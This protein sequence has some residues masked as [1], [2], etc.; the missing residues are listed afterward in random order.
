MLL[1]HAG[2]RVHRRINIDRSID[3]SVVGPATHRPSCWPARTEAV[4]ETDAKM[5][6]APL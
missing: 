1:F 6:N 2:R 3:E 4:R 5:N